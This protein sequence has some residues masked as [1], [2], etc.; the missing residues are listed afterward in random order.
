MRLIHENFAV[1][2]ESFKD[3]ESEILDRFDSIKNN[4]KRFERPT[5]CKSVSG[6]MVYARKELVFQVPNGTLVLGVT[7]CEHMTMEVGEN[8]NG[9]ATETALAHEMAHVIQHCDAGA[10]RGPGDFDE[11]HAGWTKIGLNKILKQFEHPDRN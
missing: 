7:R 10:E 4:D 11:D 9:H 5:A 2:C 1:S 8:V 6:M 3:A